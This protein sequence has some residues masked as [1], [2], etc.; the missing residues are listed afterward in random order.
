MQ[1]SSDHP[2]EPGGSNALRRYGPIVAIVAVIAVVIGLVVAGGGDDDDDEA[3]AAVDD[4]SEETTSEDG[5][6]TEAE[7]PEIQ[8]AISWT[9]AQD[10]GLDV[11]FPDTC[12]P[13]TG[14]AAIP[15]FFAAEC[16]ADVEDNGGATSQGVTEDTITVVY[17]SDPETDAVLDFITGP[18]QNDDTQAQVEETVQGFMELFGSYYQSYGRTVDLKIVRGSGASTDEVA[19]RADAQAA[20]EEHKPFAAFGGPALTSAWADE[21]AAAGVVC[22]SCGS[23]G[24]EEFRD[25]RAPHLISIGMAGNQ[26]NLHGAEYISTKLVGKPAEF[27]GDDVATTDRVFGHVYISSSEESER[28]AGQFADMLSERGVELA[29]QLSYEL[30]PGRLPEQ[31]TSVISKLKE[32]GVTSVIIQADPVA[33]ASFTQEATAQEYFPEW[34][35]VGGTLV[36]TNTFGRI[37]DQAQW[38]HAFGITTNSVPLDPTTTPGFALYEWFHGSPPPADQTAPILFPSPSLLHSIIQAAGPNLTPET[39]RDGLFAVTPTQ[40]S[41]S[42]PSLSWGNHGLWDD[43]DTENDWSGIDDVAEWWW[44]PTTTGPDEIQREGTGMMRFVAGGKRYLPGE[45]DDTVSLFDPADTVTLFDEPP[46]DER[47][48]EY[49]SPAG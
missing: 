11:T 47:A 27:G 45:W 10:E 21:M 35:V 5:S 33:P 16:Y 15:Y 49:P 19:A 43:L 29:E 46:A 28:S 48:P 2:T 39:F 25:A 34:I 8:G 12:D 32:S 14:Q 36:D 24:S 42:Q 6:E 18:I 40:R 26:I 7:T 3:T 13:E 4:T 22:I 23:T 38:E 31:A 44:D 9:Q 37:F 41:I 30:D 17:Y 20:I 1:P